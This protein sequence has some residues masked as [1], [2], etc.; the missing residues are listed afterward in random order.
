[1]NLAEKIRKNNLQIL[2]ENNISI[3]SNFLP[4]I[5]D[6]QTKPIDDICK[7]ALVLQAIV[8]YKYGFSK[9]KFMLW[10]KQ[11]NLDF[12]LTEIEKKFVNDEIETNLFDFKVE[13]LYMLVWYLG[14]IQDVGFVD[15][16]PNSLISTCPD[17]NK[18]ESSFSFINNLKVQSNET[19][20]SKV[21][22]YYCLDWYCVNQKINRK[23]TGLINPN[24]IMERRRALEWIADVDFDWDNGSL[25]T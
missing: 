6:L 15:E 11:E 10:I 4:I 14:K 1:M 12:S 23:N 9:K 17:L 8:A 20:L 16:C 18:M 24:I 5:E 7:R 2:F 22:L 19:L 21:D 25:D 13:A 3:P